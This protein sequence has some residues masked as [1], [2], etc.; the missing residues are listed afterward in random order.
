MTKMDAKN[1]HGI[2]YISFTTTF[3]TYC[4]LYIPCITR[5]INWDAKARLTTV[6]IRIRISVIR[7][8]TNI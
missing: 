3:K 4:N 6:A 8:A 1:A 2:N 7:V 5:S